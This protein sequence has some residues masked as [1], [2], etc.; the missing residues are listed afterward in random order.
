MM[1][2]C[3]TYQW[4]KQ[5]QILKTKTKTTGSKQRDLADLTFMQV[6]AML[7]STAVMFRAQNR[8]T[9]NSTWKVAVCFKIIMTT[10]V[11]RPCFTTQH[12]TCKIKTKAK[13]LVS[14][15]SCTKTDSLRPHH[16]NLPSLQAPW[17]GEGRS[18]GYRVPALNRLPHFTRTP[19]T[20]SRIFHSR[21]LHVFSPALPHSHTPAFYQHPILPSFPYR[22]HHCHP[23]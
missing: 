10:S 18:V 5:H 17:G 20:Y 23:D 4:C 15:R 11:I 9:I 13:F 1:L 12:Q 19:A 7:I 22:N 21:T 16:W 8:E 3:R 14:D 6:N 2:C